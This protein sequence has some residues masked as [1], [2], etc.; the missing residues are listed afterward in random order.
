MLLYSNDPKG[1]M[2]LKLPKTDLFYRFSILCN[3]TED[4]CVEGTQPFLASGS[5]ESA[6]QSAGIFT[7]TNTIPR[8]SLTSPLK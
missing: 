4:F 6:V 2:G 8:I 1:E 3:H 7:L 5:E